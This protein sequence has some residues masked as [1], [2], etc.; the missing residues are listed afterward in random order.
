VRIVVRDTGCGL[1]EEV[2]ERLFEPYFTTRSHGTGLGLAI[3]RRL[4]EEMNGTI[5]LVAAED[6]DGTVARIEIPEAPASRGPEA[7]DSPG[8][9]A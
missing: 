4:L 6:G 3:A 1:S 8:P 5:Q 7:T 9:A 2:R